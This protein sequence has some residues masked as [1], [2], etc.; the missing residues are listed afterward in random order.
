MAATPPACHAGWQAS[1]LILPGGD[2]QTCSPEYPSL[3]GCQP[4]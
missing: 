3:A 2:G 1:G 4:E